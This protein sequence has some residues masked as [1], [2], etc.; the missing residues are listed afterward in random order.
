[1]S[2]PA[3][4][5]TAMRDVWCWALDW[6]TKPPTNAERRAKQAIVVQ[7]IKAELASIDAVADLHDRYARG[8]GWSLDVARRCY[9]DDWRALGVHAAT[10]A[11][12][13]LRYVELMVG[14]PLDATQPLPAWVREWAAW[15]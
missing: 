4:N 2:A 6:F 14:R 3:R 15:S 9:P 11:A 8:S 13:A 12:F 10:A 5:T 1:M 7:A